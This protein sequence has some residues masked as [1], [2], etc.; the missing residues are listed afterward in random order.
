MPSQVATHA[1]TL[2]RDFVFVGG[3]MVK[4]ES[5]AVIEVVSPV[6]EERIGTAPSST[7]GDIDRAVRAAR[8]AFDDG[9]WPR[10]SP[11]ERAKLL[12]PFTEYLRCR[13]PEIAQLITE[14]MGSP[15]SFSNRLQAPVPIMLLDYYRKLAATFPFEEDRAGLSGPTRILREPVGVVG[16]IVPWNAPSSSPWPTSPPR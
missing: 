11:Q 8:T 10:M 1:T 14:E 12:E 5:D 16:Q 13:V 7:P 3:E 4:P 15:I 2:V 9:P 6:T